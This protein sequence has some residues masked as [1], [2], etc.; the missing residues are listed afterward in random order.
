LPARLPEATGFTA[1]A[2]GYGTSIAG[3]TQSAERRYATHDGWFRF[4]EAA[5]SIDVGE[6]MYNKTFIENVFEFCEQYSGFVHGDS[7]GP[8]FDEAGHLCGV[9]H[10][11]DDDRRF[12]CRRRSPSS[13]TEWLQWTASTAWTG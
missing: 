4:G 10:G 9:E 8:I 12:R 2:V 1:T 5:G 7:G 6:A 13:R 11:G 3:C